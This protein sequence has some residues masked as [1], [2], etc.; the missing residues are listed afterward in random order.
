MVLDA[1]VEG[2]GPHGESGGSVGLY[3]GVG[4]WCGFLI[5]VALGT[6]TAVGSYLWGRNVKV[7]AFEAVW[8]VGAWYEEMGHVEADIEVGDCD[9][10]LP[11]LLACRFGVCAH[12]S[13][14]E[15]RRVSCLLFQHL[16]EELGVLGVKRP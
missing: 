10:L 11:V 7:M 5:G 16:C 13:S 4:V 3:V 14:G 8:G 9:L 12:H 2:E 6:V 1:S 15:Y